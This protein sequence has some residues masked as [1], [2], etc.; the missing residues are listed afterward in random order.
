MAS[1]NSGY[2]FKIEVLTLKLRYLLHQIAARF[3]LYWQTD[4]PCS[5]NRKVL[6]VVLVWWITCELLNSSPDFTVLLLLLFTTL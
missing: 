3:T 1:K 4:K 5:H 2:Q 6:Y